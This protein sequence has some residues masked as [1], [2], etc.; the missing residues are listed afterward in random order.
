MNDTDNPIV[1]LLTV[2]RDLY[3]VMSLLLA[4]EKMAKVHNV[5]AWTRVFHENEVRR[6]MLWVAT[7]MRGLLDLLKKE[8]DTF[9]KQNCGEY[10][11]TFPIDS[12]KPPALTFRQA[13]NSVIHAK[14]I[15]P[16]RAPEQDSIKNI[17]RVYRNRITVRGTN[18]GKTT[19][20]Q[21]DIIEFVRIAYELTKSF[22]E[23]RY[24]NG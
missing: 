24:A 4:D 15:L 7:A 10:W 14:E 20:A 23:N 12:E 9:S 11:A 22:E 17:N 8:K 5:V 19:R 21:L 6:L 18:Q 3:L 13:C 1:D 16:Y 2:R